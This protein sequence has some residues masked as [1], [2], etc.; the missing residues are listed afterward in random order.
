MFGS[1]GTSEGQVRPGMPLILAVE[2]EIEERDMQ[3]ALGSK[4]LRQQGKICCRGGWI[5]ATLIK[6]VERLRIQLPMVLFLSGNEFQ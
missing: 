3:S 5:Y 4:S 2:S 1:K 6:S